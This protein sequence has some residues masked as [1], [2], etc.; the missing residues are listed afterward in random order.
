MD[1]ILNGLYYKYIY[2]QQIQFFYAKRHLFSQALFID[3]LRMILF[4][5]MISDAGAGVTVVRNRSPFFTTCR[6]W[7]T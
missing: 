6:N 1:S 3:I 7:A 4:E 2:I 5:K